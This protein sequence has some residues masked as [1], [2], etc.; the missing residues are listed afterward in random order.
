MGG[1][2][3]HTIYKTI[4][5]GEALSLAN[6]YGKPITMATLIKWIDGHV[7]KLGHQPGGEGGK[8]YVFEEPFIAFI[9]GQEALCN[10]MLEKIAKGEH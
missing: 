4:T 5:L 8:W 6:E 3:T 9:S 2:I 10:D 1:K 7:P